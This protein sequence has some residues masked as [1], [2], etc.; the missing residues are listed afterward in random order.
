M[1]S[2]SA[3]EFSV[4][5]LQGLSLWLRADA[6]VTTNTVAGVN[7][8]TGKV[9]N[10]AS[11]DGE[12]G[13]GS[14]NS[15]LYTN[16]FGIN[17]NSNFALSVWIKP[18]NFS[19]LQH[20][21]GA[22]FQN[23]FFI[24]GNDTDLTFNLYNGTLW[25]ITAP[26]VS[27]DTWNHYV[28]TRIGEMLKLYA[29][30]TFVGEVSVADESF[31]GDPV[32]SVGGGEFDEYYFNGDIDEMALWSRFLTVPEISTL[33]N[34]GNGTNYAGSPSSNM[35]SYWSLNETSGVRYD[36]HGSNH[37]SEDPSSTTGIT[38]WADQSGNG[39]NA[40]S[41]EGTRP[42]FVS[43]ILNS[44]P[45]LRFNGAG[46]KLA[47]TSS[48]GGTEYSIF[49]V[50]KNNDNTNGSMF[51]WST[52]ENYAKYIG[53]V[54]S[55]SYNAS[56]RNK[57]ILSENDV[58]SGEGD[59]I[60]AW[61][62]TAVNNNYFIGTAMQ[63][64]GGKAY[65]NGAGGTD[66]LG[67]FVESNT[68]DLI[69]GYE[70]GYELDGDVAE[71]IA[72][73]RALSDS[74]R[75]K[76]EAYLNA[77]YAIYSPIKNTK[78]SI[79]K[80]N[81]GGGKLTAKLF[82]PKDLINLQLWLKAD[83]GV[84]LSGANV[85]AWADQSGNSRNFTK[86]ISDTGFPTFSNGALLFTSSTTYDDPNAS[87]L[88][89]PSSSL[90]FTTPY[91]L[92][93]L[94]RAGANNSCVFSKSK[95]GF[96]RRKYQILVN[97]GIVYSLES[98]NNADTQIPYDTG[99]GDDVSVKRLIVSQY[100]SNTS[101]LLRYNGAQVATSSTNVGIDQTNT[102]SVFIGASPFDEGSGYN[103]EASTEMYVYEILFYNRAL[104]TIEIQQIE[105]YLNRKYLIY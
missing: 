50:C 43:N 26:T 77:K 40:N 37:L 19:N 89:L 57:F 86:S 72:Y 17:I 18:R 9:G 78:I 47:L 58:G 41:S 63:N 91:T 21:I 4:K 83:A 10:C 2:L 59:S 49:I 85:T 7:S 25:G 38:A 33:Y 102:A 79:K 14:Y 35:V 12:D 44:K 53:S 68:F 15:R 3:K 74:E 8:T 93:A 60:I 34:S 71:I 6:G 54:T 84:T 100:S 98:I 29:N 80:Q 65:L 11:F 24:S 23:G 64:G 76:V 75:Q 28:F 30:N 101:G 61:S 20:I 95:D 90:N 92:I 36:S 22:P 67:T 31:T 73:N 42:T 32:F 51:L 94:V 87:I 105:N 27:P 13:G 104:S 5:D 81:L 88:A 66:S 46:Q 70:F 55:T 1:G 82:S 97:G 16:S 103:A 56:A 52:D 48:I 69:G 62:S 96:K 39:N 45:V 99:T